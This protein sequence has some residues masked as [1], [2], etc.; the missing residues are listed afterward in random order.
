MFV[1]LDTSSVG[2]T[3]V[4]SSTPSLLAPPEMKG[5]QQAYVPY[6]TARQAIAKVVNLGC[7]VVD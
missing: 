4:S 6:D 2:K 1:V 7:I 3:M 5:E